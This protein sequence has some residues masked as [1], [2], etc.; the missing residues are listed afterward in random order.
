MLL[1]AYELRLAR[2]ARPGAPAR[3][4]RRAAAPAGELEQ[5]SRDLRGALLEIGYLDPASPD[6]VLTE[7]RRLLAAGRAA[8]RARSRLLRGVARQVGWAGR[9]ARGGAGAG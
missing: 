7:L 4:S 3:G 9:V 8:R 2:P 6:R 1:V 5:A